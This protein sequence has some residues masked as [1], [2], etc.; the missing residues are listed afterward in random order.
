MAETQKDEAASVKAYEQLKTAKEDEIVAGQEQSETKT[1][2]LADTNEKIA[3]F[4]EDLDDTRASLTEDE[5]F[6]PHDAEGE[7]RQHRF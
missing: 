5:A 4:K 2:D 6:L 1:Q 3:Q 7:V